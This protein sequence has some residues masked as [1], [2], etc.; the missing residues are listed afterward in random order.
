MLGFQKKKLQTNFSHGPV[1]KNLPDN[2]GDAVWSLYCKDP[3]CDRGTK[4]MYHNYWAQALECGSR[5]CWSLC[6][7]K[8][9]SAMR[10]ATTVRNPWLTRKSNPNLLQLVKA[11]AQ[12]WRPRIAKGGG[13]KRQGRRHKWYQF[14]CSIMSDSLHPMDCSTPGLPVHHQLLE[15]AWTHVQRV[16]DQFNHL[17]LCHPLLHIQSFPASRSFPMS[18][19]FASD[20]QSIG[21]SASASILPMNIQD[22]F[23]LGLTGL[24]SLLSKGLSRVFSNTTVQKH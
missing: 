18:Q 12:Q 3:T 7:Q 21:V 23:P 24:I 9:Y 1:I 6:I 20:G 5:N 22:W 16:G 11:H 14:S 17:I 13:K 8:L 19:L 10:E 15:L 4:P 2:A